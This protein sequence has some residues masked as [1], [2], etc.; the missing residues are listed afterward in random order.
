MYKQHHRSG[1]SVNQGGQVGLASD[2]RLPKLICE[3]AASPLRQRNPVGSEV[4]LN[5]AKITRTGLP[6]PDVSRVGH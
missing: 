3:T 6:Y 5:V 4:I 1:L 2:S